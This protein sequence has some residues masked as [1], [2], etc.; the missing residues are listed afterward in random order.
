ML[1]ILNL[2]G[3]LYQL[4]PNKTGRKYKFNNKNFKNNT[5]ISTEKLRSP[6][7]NNR[8]KTKREHYWDNQQHLSIYCTMD[9]YPE[10]FYF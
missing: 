7:L 3:A 5:K 6:F 1:Y 10:N 8:L 4:Y 2:Y 9:F